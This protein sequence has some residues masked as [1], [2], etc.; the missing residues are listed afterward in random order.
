MKILALLCTAAFDPQTSSPLLCFSDSR[1]EFF[2]LMVI[3]L[4]FLNINIRNN[5]EMKKSL[6]LLSGRHKNKV[7]KEGLVVFLSDNESHCCQM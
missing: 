4:R 2:G 5:K 1:A 7:Q 3:M 6:G